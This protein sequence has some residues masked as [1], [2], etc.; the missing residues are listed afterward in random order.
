MDGPPTYALEP[1]VEV[2]HLESHF[3]ERDYLCKYCVRDRLLEL[4]KEKEDEN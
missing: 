3:K 4:S 1:R 2:E